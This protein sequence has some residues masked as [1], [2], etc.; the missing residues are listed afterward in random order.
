M[1][2]PSVLYTRDAHCEGTEPLRDA[3]H[4]R[5]AKLGPEHPHTVGS[6]RE[7]VR[8][9]ES[10]PQPD[11]AAKWQAKLPEPAQVE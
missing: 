5:E 11:E 4:G 7:L 8:L 9:Y 1:H 2:E 6:L 10:W 3:F